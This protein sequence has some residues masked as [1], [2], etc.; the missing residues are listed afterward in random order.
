[1]T[2]YSLL[3]LLTAF[4]VAGQSSSEGR[5][6]QAAAPAQT[7]YR[8]CQIK[9]MYAEKRYAEI[10]RLPPPA[11]DSAPEIDYY[12]GMAFARLK[13][14]DEAWKALRQGELR[15]P[16]D[17]RFPVEMAGADFERKRY[18][19]AKSELRRALRLSPKDAYAT[20]FLASLYYLD[21]N[22]AAA[23]KYWNRVG[24]PKLQRILVD[25]PPRLKPQILAQALPFEPGKAMTLPDYNSSAER[26]QALGVFPQVRDEL[27]PS[28]D[29]R[30]NLTLHALE[31]NGWGNS[32]PEALLSL[33]RG[34]PY[35]SVYP[36]FFN[37]HHSALN[38]TSMVRWDPNKQRVFAALSGPWHASARTRV[39]VYL[40]GRQENWE[41]NP[42]FSGLQAGIAAFRMRRVE[43]GA[44][45]LSLVNDRLAVRGGI[46]GSGRSFANF[47]FQSAQLGRFFA[48]GFELEA[49]SSARYRL[50]DL[51][52]RRL[53]LAASG[54]IE[55]GH[56][57]SGALGSFAQ[58]EGGLEAHWLPRASGDD[59]EMTAQVRAG[60]TVGMVPFDQL[61][62]L[63]LERD[64]NLWLR[65]HVGT[66]QGRKGS[67]PLGRDYTLTNWEDD[68]IIFQNG[69]FRVRMGPFLD[70]GRIRDPSGILGSRRWLWDTGLELKIRIL[71]GTEVA[72][73]L[74]KDLLT[75]RTS[76]YGT[77]LG[78]QD[79][80]FPPGPAPFRGD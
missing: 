31:L 38:F 2:P 74:G 13:Q 58:A 66:E 42:E 65:G 19:R 12:R 23:L 5:P 73:F 79:R 52:D 25:P 60:R 51:P 8:L 29:G 1:M 57:F 41:L 54:S 45:I 24:K 56:D 62:M 37:L 17:E 43:G 55:A 72:V 6:S 69:I 18:G 33:L 63:G 11:Q 71:G 27:F 3:V 76:V 4:A 50:L 10:I 15:A 70:S 75:G 61:F 14:W 46:D 68:K 21:G 64:N 30:Y 35:E 22:L 34:V 16:Q 7:A 28:S 44:E 40:D 78:F 48:N 80:P 9:K 32:T 47:T 53:S 59:Y 20:D 49:R 77:A 36:Q 26:L 39:Q 67:A